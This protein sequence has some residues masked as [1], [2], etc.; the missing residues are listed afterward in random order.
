MSATYQFNMETIWGCKFSFPLYIIMNLTYLMPNLQNLYITILGLLY[1]NYI[2]LKT[3]LELSILKYIL[4]HSLINSRNT[5]QGCFCNIY[6][7]T[8]GLPFGIEWSTRQLLSAN[9]ILV[10]GSLDCKQHCLSGGT[11]VYPFV[12]FRHLFFFLTICIWHNIPM[13]HLINMR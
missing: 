3:V 8:P 4:I 13:A 10:I 7:K 11:F 2:Q 6:M 1:G 5:L 12:I 9:R